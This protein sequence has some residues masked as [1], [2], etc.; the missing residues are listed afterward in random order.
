MTAHAYALTALGTGR[1]LGMALLAPEA[2]Y[3][4]VL[5]VGAPRVDRRFLKPTQWIATENELVIGHDK[6][7]LPKDSAIA[8]ALAGTAAIVVQFIHATEIDPGERGAAEA[9]DQH[10][11]SIVSAA[12]DSR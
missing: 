6:G 12:G 2:R 1:V 11:R 3:A 8:K 10:L 5:A 7:P 9:L 4:G